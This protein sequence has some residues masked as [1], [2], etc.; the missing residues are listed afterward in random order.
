MMTKHLKDL[1]DVW[2]EIKSQ[3][4]LLKVRTRSGSY[5]TLD[6]TIIINIDEENIVE[7][8]RQIVLLKEIEPELMSS[9]NDIIQ[10]IASEF[11]NNCIYTSKQE[12]AQAKLQ[13]Y[14]DTIQIDEANRDAIHVDFIRE[15]ASLIFNDFDFSDSLM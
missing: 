6:K 14:I 1:K 15:L 11:D 3:L 12:W 7:P 2:E 5:L 8:F 13:E 10:L 4:L 9:N